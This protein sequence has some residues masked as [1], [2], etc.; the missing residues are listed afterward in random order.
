MLKVYVWRL[1]KVY[2]VLVPL[3]LY[4]QRMRQGGK[5]FSVLSDVVQILNARWFGVEKRV[6]LRKALVQ[7]MS[8]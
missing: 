6:F 3:R 5:G 2:P 8:V 4:D 1:R 7:S